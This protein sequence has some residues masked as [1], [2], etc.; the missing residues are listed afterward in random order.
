MFKNW[1]DL[2]AKNAKTYI[3]VDLIENAKF[4]KR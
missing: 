1:N 3:K 4:A 2:T